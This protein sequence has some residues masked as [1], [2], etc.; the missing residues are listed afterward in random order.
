MQDSVS[1][2]D[3]LLVTKSLEVLN[4][5]LLITNKQF[6]LDTIEVGGAENQF[7]M[8]YFRRYAKKNNKE[9]VFNIYVYNDIQEDYS[10]DRRNIRA[11]A[12]SIPGRTIATRKQWMATSTISHE[13][14]HCGGLL[15]IQTADPTDGFSSETGDLICDI[16]SIV[17]IDDYVSG[18]CHYIN[19][20]EKT[21]EDINTDYTCNIMSYVANKCRRC[22]TDGQISR[23]NKVIN[24][25]ED[26]RKIFGIKTDNL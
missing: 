12:G 3:S 1:R 8:P 20:I 16:R 17:N 25:S 19:E 2:E 14:L 21:E 23:L 11:E 7:E 18:E 15:H 4:T 5:H 9:K 22:V 13:L 10:G 6:V 24:D 26:L